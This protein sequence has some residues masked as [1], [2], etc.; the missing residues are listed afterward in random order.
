MT[1]PTSA[2]ETAPPGIEE[3]QFEPAEA[4]APPAVGAQSSDAADSAIKELLGGPS[5]SAQPDRGGAD[6]AAPS[7][8]ES[9]PQPAEAQGLDAQPPED[10]FEAF[11]GGETNDATIPHTPEFL[12]STPI[13]AGANPFTPMGATQKRTGVWIIVGIVVLVVAILAALVIGFVMAT[14]C[15]SGSTSTEALSH[16]P[17]PAAVAHAD[18]PCAPTESAPWLQREVDD[19]LIGFRRGTTR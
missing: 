4:E 5:D 3:A 1:A 19:E 8:L 9:P 15:S 18:P 17:P 14:G 12:P 13:D 10:V 6:E 2:P 11:G 7:F 16:E